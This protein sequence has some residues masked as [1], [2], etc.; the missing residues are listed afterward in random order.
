MMKADVLNIFEEIK[1]CTAYELPSGE[2]IEKLPFEINELDIKPVYKRMKG[3]YCSLADV[4]QYEE[5]P[6]ALKEYVTFL[7]GELQVP[8]KLVSV[9]PDR[10]QTIM[11]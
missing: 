11:R 7:E 4:T 9:G 2:Q 6:E 10:T 5:F 8:I 3:W 1:V